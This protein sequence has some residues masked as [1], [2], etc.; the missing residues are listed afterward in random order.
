MAQYRSN[1]GKK[2]VVDADITPRLNN[3][4]N[5][6]TVEYRTISWWDI[7]KVWGKN[8]ISFLLLGVLLLTVVYAGLSATVLYFASN[9]KGNFFV[10]R[11]AYVGGKIPA[12][13]I[14]YASKTDTIENTFISNLMEGFTGLTNPV[15]V[16]TLAGPSAQVYVYPE[17]REVVEIN[18]NNEIVKTFEGTLAEGYEPTDGW[19]KEQYLVECVSGKCKTGEL[20]ILDKNQISG[21]VVTE[22]KA[23]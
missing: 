13:E 4:S 6:I 8:I 22:F 23:S 20:L 10:V 19:L 2:R 21:K 9:D 17:T 5:V 15:M 11:G 3:S 18:K 16:K 1:R 12:K 7:T 14:V